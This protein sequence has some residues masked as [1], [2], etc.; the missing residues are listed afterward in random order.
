[1]ENKQNKFQV[2]LRERAQRLSQPLRE[3]REETVKL[4]VFSIGE[5]FYGFEAAHVREVVKAERITFV[6]CAP[7]FIEGVI[8]L[9]GSIISVIDLAKILNIQDATR[10]GERWLIVVEVGSIEAALHI[11]LV[12]GVIDVPKSSIK[13]LLV[14]LERGQTE[15]LKGEAHIDNYLVGILDLENILVAEEI[16][17]ND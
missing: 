9:R 8:N 13:P 12:R 4:I 3:K 6:P 16:G 17:R 14:T 15:H 10:I 5:E 2:I 7:D 1:M 11:D